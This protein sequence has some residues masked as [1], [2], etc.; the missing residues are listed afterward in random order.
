MQLIILVFSRI[1]ITNDL[2]NSYSIL[3]RLVNNSCNKC[4]R[5]GLITE[6]CPFTV[7]IKNS[8]YDEE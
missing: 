1:F 3:S 5:K 7:Y 6:N 2:Q 8:V 4:K